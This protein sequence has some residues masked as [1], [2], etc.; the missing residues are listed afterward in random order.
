MNKYDR[1]ASIINSESIRSKSS[2]KDHQEKADDSSYSVA[3]F[4]S[5]LEKK[6]KVAERTNEV[7]SGLLKDRL[8][9]LME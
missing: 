6:Y 4:D 8:K 7:I 3:E 2:R 5:Y 1:I 9:E